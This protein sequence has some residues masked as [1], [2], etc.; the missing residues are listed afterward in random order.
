[1]SPETQ[2]Q[3]KRS[4][5]HRP[6]YK[7]VPRKPLLPSD[8]QV[9]RIAAWIQPRYLEGFVMLGR[10]AGLRQMEAGTLRWSQITLL[11]EGTARLRITSGKGERQGRV[12]THD[13]ILMRPGLLALPREARAPHV[14]WAQRVDEPTPALKL[15][16]EQGGV[17]WGWD[18]W[19]F[20]SSWGHPWDS[21]MLNQKWREA[22]PGDCLHVQYRDLRHFHATW[23]LEQGFSIEEV[24]V[25]LRHFHLSGAPNIQHVSF[26]YGHPRAFI[27][28]QRISDLGARLTEEMDG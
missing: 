25:Q 27:A 10:W 20:P 4:T 7:W 14:D 26:T 11:P 24:A 3:K 23:L 2:R 13:C 28:L 1:M 19:L 9:R 16:A 17:E 22:L 12:R 8:E 6:K 5:A 21:G 18:G 15:L